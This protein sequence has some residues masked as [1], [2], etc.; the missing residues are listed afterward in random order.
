MP[1]LEAF[2]GVSQ[3]WIN[4][5]SAVASGAV[6][7]AIDEGAE[8]MRDAINDSPTGHPWHL[9]KNAANGFTSNQP[10]IGNTNPS[11]GEVDPNSGLMLASVGTKGPINPANS[12]VI[13]SYGWVKRQEQYFIDQDTGGYDVGAGAGMGLLNGL[14]SGAGSVLRDYGAKIAAEE[15]LFASLKAAGLKMRSGG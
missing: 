9:R 8:F 13:G 1:N 6:K 5:I 12:G 3:G 15:K 10:R 2:G 4:M 11:F 14:A 7:D